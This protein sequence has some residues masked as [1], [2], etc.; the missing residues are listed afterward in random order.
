MH[1]APQLFS[2]LF[3]LVL[4]GKAIRVNFLPVHPLWRGHVVL[5]PNTWPALNLQP[6]DISQVRFP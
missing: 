1:N 2:Y 5:L 4:L 6:G 3:S